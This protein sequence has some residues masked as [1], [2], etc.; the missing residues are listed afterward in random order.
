MLVIQS[1]NPREHMIDDKG[2]WDERGTE[3]REKDKMSMRHLYT[4]HY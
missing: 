2:A 1:D 4:E 3:N